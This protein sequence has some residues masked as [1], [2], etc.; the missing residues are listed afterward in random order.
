[1]VPLW[2]SQVCLENKWWPPYF[3]NIAFLIC[4]RNFW[5]YFSYNLCLVEVKVTINAS[6]TFP[7]KYRG[8]FFIHGVFNLGSLKATTTDNHH[9]YFEHPISSVACCPVHYWSLKSIR[10]ISAGYH[11]S[12]DNSK[13]PSPVLDICFLGGKSAPS[14]EHCIVT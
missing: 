6:Q 13:C 14:W 10:V 8:L 1:M 3:N 5:V 4:L 12:N 7:H 2:N 9:W 11:P